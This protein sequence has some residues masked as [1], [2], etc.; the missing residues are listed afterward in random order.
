VYIAEA[1]AVDEWP[2]NSSRCSGP[3]NSVCRPRTLD[4][5]RQ[6]AQQMTERLGLRTRVLCDGV[7]DV[8][9]SAFA[10]WP[11]RLYGLRELR[12]EMIAKP[13]ECGFEIGQL[14]AWLEQSC[15]GG[16]ASGGRSQRL[17]AAPQNLP[18]G[19]RMH[20]FVG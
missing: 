6:V 11:I 4:D 3:A 9:S 2:I 20:S 15:A 19:A 7:D 10:A 8:F 13:R 17:V 12:V 14:R 18:P 16:A 5:R 1:H